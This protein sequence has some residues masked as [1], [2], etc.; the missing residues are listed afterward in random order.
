[1]PPLDKEGREQFPF[2][3]PHCSTKFSSA[4]QQRVEIKTDAARK[5]HPVLHKGVMWHEGPISVCEPWF[6]VLCILHMKLSFAR[7]L[8]EW[9]IKPAALIQK[10]DV[11]VKKILHMLQADGVNI[12][13]LRKLNNSN[14]KETA[15][16]ASFDGDSADRILARFEEYM[17]VAGSHDPASG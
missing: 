9:K 11:V 7:T 10:D 12:N 3:C 6:L 14:D 16:K 17:A 4:E 8:W 15:K 2:R 1:M 5:E 13:R